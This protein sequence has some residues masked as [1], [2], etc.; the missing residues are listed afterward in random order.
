M[1]TKVKF[2][3]LMHL[4]FGDLDIFFRQEHAA[5]RISSQSCFNASIIKVDTYQEIIL[6][7]INY[8][9]DG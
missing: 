2:K 1:N 3:R 5:I 9:S 4:T 6:V 8:S 7:V